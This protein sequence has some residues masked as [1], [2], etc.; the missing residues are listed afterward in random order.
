M[1]F[2]IQTVDKISKQ[3]E[4]K[5]KESWKKHDGA[6]NI[7]SNYHPFW[8]LMTDESNQEL[9]G[10]IKALTIY[11]EI[12]V[13]MLWVE[14][15][16]RKQGFGKTL[17]AELEKNFKEKGYWNINLW[18]SEFLAPKFYE[19]CGY[20]LEFVRK[21]PKNPKLTK[22]S[23][24][25]YFKEERL[26]DENYGSDY[27]NEIKASFS[28]TINKRNCYY[29]KKCNE[30]CQPF[31]EYKYSVAKGLLDANFKK[32]FNNKKNEAGKTFSRLV[33]LNVAYNLKKSGYKVSNGSLGKDK[34]GPD[35]KIECKDYNIFI[36]C[37]CYQD[38][39]KRHSE[40][41]DINGQNTTQ[42]GD[43]GPVKQGCEY[44]TQD[45]TYGKIEGQ[46]G[47]DDIKKSRWAN[48]ILDKS[49]D[50]EK[51]QK[52][53]IIKEH[54]IIVLVIGDEKQNP[55]QHEHKPVMAYKSFGSEITFDKNNNMVSSKKY[56]SEEV[57]G[58]YFEK[59]NVKTCL[60]EEALD[61]FHAFVFFDYCDIDKPYKLY[62]R[63]LPD[64][65]SKEILEK[66]FD[67]NAIE[68]DDSYFYRVDKPDDYYI[69]KI[70]EHTK[71]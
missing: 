45:T 48:S 29:F 25:K 64:E 26:F 35:F 16:Y 22:Y 28:K 49:K 3:L 71:N 40:H 67:T 1:K 20:E 44:S 57:L 2:N 62:V 10:M 30:R 5:V 52:N 39:Q 69:E 65:R 63:R 70:S 46:F 15:K 47:D 24:V 13:D 18:T 42:T 6:H 17:L 38:T 41:T 56:L 68:S 32:E 14:E 21:N 53:G 23:F 51:W 59:N 4:E 58:K 43:E 11:D 50:V 37:T 54:D 9:I 19:K 7:D 60:K 12:Y 33:E 27:Y 61:R 66:V 31:F 55:E 8:M 36:E 34:G